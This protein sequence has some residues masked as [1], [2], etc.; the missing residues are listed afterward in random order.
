LGSREEK[1]K[2]WR[3]SGLGRRLLT[4]DEEA[5][6]RVGLWGKELALLRGALARADRKA[7][8]PSQGS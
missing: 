6:E 8:P 2:S 7:G 4:G 3:H 1:L 5:I